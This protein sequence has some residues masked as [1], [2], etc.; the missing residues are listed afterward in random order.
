MKDLDYVTVKA[1]GVFL[2][3]RLTTSYRGVEFESTVIEDAMTD[4]WH[5]CNTLKYDIKELHCL[6]SETLGTNDTVGNPSERSGRHIWGRA[7]FSD[8]SITPWV[9]I[10]D[11]AGYG[12]R[13][14]PCVVASELY[15]QHRHKLR[16]TMLGWDA[17]AHR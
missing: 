2:G 8:D 1:D 12:I 7:K 14:I 11:G 16:K 13:C 15:A 4:F 6:A 5:L 10:V 17:R 9:Y 3:G